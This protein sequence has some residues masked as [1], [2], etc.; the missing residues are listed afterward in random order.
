MAKR[1]PPP[2]LGHLRYLV[3]VAEH[4]SFGKAGVALVRYRFVID[5]NGLRLGAGQPGSARKPVAMS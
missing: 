1:F 2:E 4:G 5:M 3:A